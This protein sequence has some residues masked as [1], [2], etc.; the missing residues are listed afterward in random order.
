MLRRSVPL[1]LLPVCLL[2]GT[3]AC[4]DD[5]DG[6]STTGTAARADSEKGP[7]SEDV[8]AFFTAMASR[9]VADLEAIQGLA[10]PG[11]PA[12]TYAAY[13]LGV[14]TAFVEEGEPAPSA[15]LVEVDGGWQACDDPADESTCVTWTEIEGTDGAIASFL[16][17]DEPVADLV[18]AG[19]GEA[20]EVPGHGS[21]EMRVAY[22]SPTSGALFVVTEVTADADEVIV[23]FPATYVDA[24]GARAEQ[25]EIWGDTTL[26]QD[27]V[28]TVVHAFA[29][30][31][32]GGRIR[33]D[34]IVD[35]TDGE[36]V[37]LPVG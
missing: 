5:G 3:A 13:G 28:A 19:D 8:E 15:T 31:E 1:V 23:G 17:N 29:D 30:A 35:S 10:A 12:A 26:E 9:Q 25:V 21:A 14:A 22:T 7:S 37:E 27:Q 20:I 34:L 32:P 36:P 18:V 6:D 4:S 24:D 11:S 33:Y 2:L 16:V